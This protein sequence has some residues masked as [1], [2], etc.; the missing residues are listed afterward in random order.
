MFRRKSKKTKIEKAHKLLPPKSLSENGEGDNPVAQM[1]QSIRLD[2]DY[3]HHRSLATQ[4]KIWWHRTF[5]NPRKASKDTDTTPLTSRLA[6]Q[7]L[8]IFL[9]NG[10]H[11]CED[12]PSH[13]LEETK[14]ATIGSRLDLD[15]L[16]KDNTQGILSEDSLESLEFEMYERNFQLA[17]YESQPNGDFR[18]QW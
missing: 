12:Y 5:I 4:I 17:P 16:V 18:D 8:S 2:K 13:F 9:S 6:Q 3:K 11:Q 10:D 7:E 1:A 15:K 14:A